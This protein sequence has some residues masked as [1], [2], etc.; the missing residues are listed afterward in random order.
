MAVK[1]KAGVGPIR[2]HF[3][4]DAAPLTCG[5]AILFF[6]HDDI[7]LLH[8]PVPGQGFPAIGDGAVVGDAD[9]TLTAGTGPARVA[10]VHH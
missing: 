6:R 8:C 4:V 3:L 2:Q 10:T 7:T 5:S 9:A 1:G